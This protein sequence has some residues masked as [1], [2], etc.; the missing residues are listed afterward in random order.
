MPYYHVKDFVRGLDVRRMVET[1]EAGSLI[2]AKNCVITRGGEIEKRKQWAPVFTLPD[3]TYGLYVEDAIGGRFHVFGSIAN[4][5]MPDARVIYHR[6]QHPDGHAMEF[7]HCVRFFMKKFY[8]VAEYAND[9][10]LNFYDGELV[11]EDPY[12]EAPPAEGTTPDIPNEHP[13]GGT[14]ATVRVDIVREKENTQ[15]NLNRIFFVNWASWTNDTTW[16]FTAYD[17]Y[18][19]ALTLEADDSDE[20]VAEKIANA[21]NGYAGAQDFHAQSDGKKLWISF[22]DGGSDFNGYAVTFDWGAAGV[23]STTPTYAVTSGGAD[24]TG[25]A[26]MSPNPAAVSQSRFAPGRYV[27]QYKDKMFAVGGDSGILRSSQL[28]APDVWSPNYPGAQFW[29]F[30]ESGGRHQSTLTSLAI[31]QD[32]LAVFAG[33]A[34]YVWFM[35]ELGEAS[36]ENSIVHKSG[37]FAPRSVAEYGNTDVFYLDQTGIRSLKSRDINGAAFASD[38]GSPIDDL[39]R[40]TFRDASWLASRADSVIDPLDGR[41]ICALYN[42]DTGGTIFYVFSYFTQ[43]KIAAWTLWEVE[44]SL[45]DL[46]V[47]SANM[48]ARDRNNIY[49]YGDAP[50]LGVDN[51]YDDTEVVVQLPYLHAGKPASQKNLLG[52]D[53]ALEGDWMVE[54]GTDYTNPD[55]LEEV[56]IVGDTTYAQQRI[57]MVGYGTHASFRLT[58]NYVGKARIGSLAY[59]YTMGEEPG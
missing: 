8:V 58:T 50:Q 1:T 53:A 49:V 11:I 18:L 34:V 35:D 14:R 23:L 51:E 31:F 43:T 47:D 13:V 48:Y 17:A 6:L 54:L 42:A 44:W 4:P 36:A 9:D 37:T 56:G 30:S 59:H 29:D 5:G 33:K 46:V 55:L 24:T 10:I 45:E 12:P 27:L 40:D 28:K 57:A 38:I 16:D 19:G 15:V 32:K 22:A 41:Y 7:V 39:V 3:N 20:L 26:M 52:F 25:V 21:I 2:R